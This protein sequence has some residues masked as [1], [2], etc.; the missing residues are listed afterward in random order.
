[1]ISFTTILIIKFMSNS[2]DV[3]IVASTMLLQQS[4]LVYGGLNTVFTPQLVGEACQLGCPKIVLDQVCVS[5]Q[6][7]HVVLEVHESK[8]H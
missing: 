8:T 2:I 7:V 3:L 1:M 5:P 6:C 4:C